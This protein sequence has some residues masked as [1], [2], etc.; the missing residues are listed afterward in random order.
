LATGSTI[1]PQLQFMFYCLTCKVAIPALLLLLLVVQVW[2]RP[3]LITNTP[4]CPAQCVI[5]R[6]IFRL[7]SYPIWYCW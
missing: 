7:S 4:G 3:C 5:C 6:L 1:T 2:S